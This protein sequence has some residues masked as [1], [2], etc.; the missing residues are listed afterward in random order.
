MRKNCEQ[1]KD[2]YAQDFEKSLRAYMPY[3]S[4]EAPRL[5]CGTVHGMHA[6]QTDICARQGGLGFPNSY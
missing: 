5:C 2:L 4:G 3:V 6:C 1:I